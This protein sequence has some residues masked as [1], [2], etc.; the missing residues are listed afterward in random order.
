MPASNGNSYLNYVDLDVDTVNFFGPVNFQRLREIKCEY[1]PTNF[2]KNEKSIP[3]A[4]SCAGVKNYKGKKKYRRNN[5]VQY[6]SVKYQ[7]IKKKVRK[8]N[9]I[10]WSSKSDARQ[11]SWIELGTCNCKDIPTWNSKPKYAVGD[12]VQYKN[13]MWEAVKQ[14][15]KKKP[16]KKTSAFWGNIGSC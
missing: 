5:K 11:N 1:D 9:P 12:V 8:K 3:C 2:F 7:A 15:K 4:A 6:R 14:Q 16:S 10:V 13:K